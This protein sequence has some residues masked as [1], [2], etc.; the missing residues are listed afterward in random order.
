VTRIP[1]RSTTRSAAS[2]EIIER[3]V[4]TSELLIVCDFEG[5]L[6]NLTDCRALAV[7]GSMR[8]I[9]A[10]ATLPRTSVAIIS[11][12]SVANLR[13]GGR[14][15]LGENVTVIA[16]CTS[17]NLVDGAQA[18]T[19]PVMPRKDLA[20]DGLLAQYSPSLIFFA[21]DD[22]SDEPVFAALGID[23]VGCKIGDGATSATFRLQNPLELVDFLEC[24][25]QQRRSVVRP[26]RCATAH[27]A[28]PIEAVS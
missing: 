27:A 4:T 24:V 2:D 10:L 16:R 22:E 18:R 19:P 9:T 1:S 28:P 3:L 11:Q 15:G 6:A 23:D 7:D 12:D 20:I 5:T 13:T 21:G 25:L 8:V 14:D 17:E 26:R